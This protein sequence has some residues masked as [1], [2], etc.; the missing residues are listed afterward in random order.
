[1]RK[2]YG[3]GIL[4]YLRA[5]K[6]ELTMIHYEKAWPCS[7][8]AEQRVQQNWQRSWLWEMRCCVCG[9]GYRGY[10]EYNSYN[11]SYGF[12]SDRFG[13][14][15]NYCLSWMLD[16]RYGD[17]GSVFQSTTLDTVYT[18]IP[19]KEPL[20][21]TFVFVHRSSLG[22][23]TLRLDLIAD[24]PVKV[25]SSL[26]AMKMP[27]RLCKD[28]ANTQRRYVDLFLNSTAGSSSGAYSSQTLGGKG[29]SNSP[30]TVA[31][32]ASGRIVW[33]WLRQWMRPSLQE[34]TSDFHWNFAWVAKE[35]WVALLH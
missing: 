23:N 10:V 6:L 24:S 19:Y 12:V 7:S 8:Q 11:D 15:L 34:N 2:D 13:R 28:K 25:L 3:V 35:L 26:Q 4:K 9:G 30:V 27:L 5:V 33:R 1:M 18:Y 20:R 31:Q 21:K 22:Q 32:P 14:D 16:H 29:S 17:G